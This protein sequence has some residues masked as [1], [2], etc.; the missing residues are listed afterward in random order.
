LERILDKRGL[1]ERTNFCQEKRGRC[2]KF[3][4]LC[5]YKELNSFKTL[6]AANSGEEIEEPDVVL[7]F[8]DKSTTTIR[9][10]EIIEPF[11]Q[12]QDYKKSTDLY[13]PQNYYGI[14]RAIV[15]LLEEDNCNSHIDTVIFTG[16]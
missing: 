16:N 1:L 12:I 10:D 7:E 4:S 8:P 15:E 11:T 14:A 6:F 9:R 3:D 5:K 13:F 2:D